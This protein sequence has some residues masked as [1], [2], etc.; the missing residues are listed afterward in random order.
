V[1]SRATLK[2]LLN[3]VMAAK[4]SGEEVNEYDAVSDRLDTWESDRAEDIAREESTTARAA[5]SKAI[6]AAVG[7]RY[8]ISV[9]DGQ[10]CPYC[11]ALDGKTIGIE[12]TFLSKGDEFQPDGAGS[13]LTVTRNLSHPAY[14]VGCDCDIAI[15]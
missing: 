11:D 8:I 1:T 9:S 10:N 4:E 6:Y 2:G 5:I 12:Q 15:A 3:D 7:V 14:H 13:P